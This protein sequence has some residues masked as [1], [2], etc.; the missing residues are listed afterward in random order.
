[1]EKVPKMQF[2]ILQ[3]SDIHIKSASD[4]CVQSFV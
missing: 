3:L 1:L 2:A 4:R